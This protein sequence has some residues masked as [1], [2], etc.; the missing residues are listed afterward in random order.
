MFLKGGAINRQNIIWNYD[1]DAI[2]RWK[3]GQTGM[4]LVDAN[5]RE[6]LHTGWMSNRGRQNVASYLVLDLGVDWRVGADYFESFLLDY[7]VPSNYGNWNAAAGLTGGRVNKFNIVKQSHDYDNRGDYIRYWCPELA[8]IPAPF[9]FE[10]WKLSISDQEKY[11]CVIGRDYS[12]PIDLSSLERKKPAPSGP[13]KGPSGSTTKDRGSNEQANNKKGPGSKDYRH[14]GGRT[15]KDKSFRPEEKV[16]VVERDDF[17]LPP[18][19]ASTVSTN[20]A[21]ANRIV[22]NAVQASQQ[23]DSEEPKRLFPPSKL[24]RVQHF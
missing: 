18:P 21:I 20:L 8:K 3:V 2:H 19:P 16:R 7:D 10:P 17:P 23:G 14:R 22:L 4:P 6:L 13:K 5:M 15:P 11:S 24:G 12:A 9:I 1:D